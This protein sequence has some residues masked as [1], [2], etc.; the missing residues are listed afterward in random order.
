MPQ[1]ADKLAPEGPLDVRRPFRTP[2]VKTCMSCVA[3][4]KR[5][6]ELKDLQAAARTLSA[7]PQSDRRR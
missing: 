4:R 7:Q 5:E 3:A 2:R 1:L 6:T